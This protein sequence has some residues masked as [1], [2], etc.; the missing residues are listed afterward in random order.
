MH[1]HLFAVMRN[2]KVKVVN[3][4]LRL[5]DL[6]QDDCHQM[7]RFPQAAVQEL[8]DLVRGDIQHPTTRSFA[9]PVTLRSL[10]PS[11]SLLRAAF[12][13]SSDVAA[14]CLSRLC[15]W[16]WMGSPE[17]LLGRPQISSVSPRISPRSSLIRRHSTLLPDSQTSWGLWIAPL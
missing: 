9:I 5:N 15:V 6:S 17:P 14:G 16:P 8:C 1:A 12:N 2:R 7:T 4:P 3:T 11:N 10:P 13:G